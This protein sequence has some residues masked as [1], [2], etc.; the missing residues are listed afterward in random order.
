MFRGVLVVVDGNHIHHIVAGECGG[1]VKANQVHRDQLWCN[2]E[3]HAWPIVYK[4]VG[5]ARCL[6]TVNIRCSAVASVAKCVRK[7]KL[8]ERRPSGVGAIVR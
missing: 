7:G 4:V 6:T 1:S 2:I 3:R 5:S 8:A